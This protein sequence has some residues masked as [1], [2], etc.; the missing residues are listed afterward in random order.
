M[1]SSKPF[2]L[3]LAKLL[4]TTLKVT[5]PPFKD[6]DNIRIVLYNEGFVGSTGH[7]GNL[8]I[9][10]NIKINSGLDRNTLSQYLKPL[11]NGEAP[12]AMH[13]KSVVEK[14]PNRYEYEAQSRQR[15]EEDNGGFDIGGFSSFFT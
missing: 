14:L 12:N 8:I 3:T 10:P 4:A 11:V 6:F 5:V 15:C 13:V 1:P 2:V 9:N 7:K